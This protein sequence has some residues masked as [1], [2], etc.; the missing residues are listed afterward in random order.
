MAGE[1]RLQIK[2]VKKLIEYDVICRKVV[3]QGRRGCPDL[4][5]KARGGRAFMIEVKNPN[6]Q[7]RLSEFQLA[8]HRILRDYGW[9]VYVC[10]CIEDLERVID[11]EGLERRP[12]TGD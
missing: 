2:L 6:K 4:L 10:E 5:C 1:S 11:R 7:G 9:P 3:Y 8:E 12:T